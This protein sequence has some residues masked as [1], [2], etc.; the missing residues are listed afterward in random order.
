MLSQRANS[1]CHGSPLLV[2]VDLAEVFFGKGNVDSSAAFAAATRKAWLYVGRVGTDV[3]EENI[4]RYLKNKFPNN[5]FEV[6]ML[7]EREN[8]NSV[9]FK[10]GAD[11]SLSEELNK[12]E[13]WPNGVLV[14]RFCFFRKNGL[15]N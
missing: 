15:P 13:S 5:T 14:E 8:S 2:E 1:N 9:A 6:E 10:V 3:K 11:M 7:P 12:T 4:V